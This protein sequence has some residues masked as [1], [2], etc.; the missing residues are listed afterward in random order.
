MTRFRAEWVDARGERVEAD[1]E[2]RDRRAVLDGLD[3]AA[4]AGLVRLAPADEPEGGADVAWAGRALAGLLR[5]G[6]PLGPALRHLAGAGDG[7]VA[8]ELERAAGAADEGASLAAVLERGPLGPALASPL[9][10]GMLEAGERASRLPDLLLE[11]SRLASRLTAARRRA[12]EALAYPTLVACL[13]VLLAATTVTLAGPALGDLAPVLPARPRGLA[14]RGARLARRAPGL[15]WAGA[16][17]ALAGARPRAARGRRRRLAPAPAAGCAGGAPPSA[18]RP[19]LGRAGARRAAALL[20]DAAPGLPPDAAG[21]LRRRA[22]GRRARRRRRRRPGG[23]RRPGGRRARGPA[24]PRVPPARAGRPPAHRGRGPR[25]RPG[26]LA[27]PRAGARGGRRRPPRGLALPREP[28]DVTPFWLELEPGAWLAAFVG[29]AVLLGSLVGVVRQRR[30]RAAEALRRRV[31]EQLLLAA[32][33]GL[34]LARALDVLGDEL[35]ARAERLPGWGDL[36]SMSWPFGAFER[37]GLRAQARAAH[38]LAADLAEGGLGCLSRA[39]GGAFP[40]PLPDLLA[41]AERQGTLLATLEEVVRLDDDALRLRGHV[42]GRLLYPAWVLGVM[43]LVLTFHELVIW[44]KFV[45]LSAAMGARLDPV[46]DTIAL[47]DRLVLARR[48][49]LVAAPLA[50]LGLW[51]AG[52]A[53]VTGRGALLRRVVPGLGGVARAVARARALRLLLAHLRAGAPLPDA[54]AALDRQGLLPAGGGA[55]AR[56]RA[57]EGH[58]IRA[59]LAASGVCGRDLLEPLPDGGPHAVEALAAVADRADRAARARIDLV[60]R[61]TLP[62]ALA[63]LGA[64]AAVSYLAPHLLIHAYTRS[65]AIW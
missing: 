1:L 12:L 15:A 6:V 64:L 36:T 5:Q 48:V 23:A 49:L 27:G 37:Q 51:L 47:A 11:A 30:R 26:R 56:A 34:P 14:R 46:A 16:L 10:R 65:V 54:V 39:P 18:G 35:A 63:L 52:S 24:R 29:L 13:G 50:L 44:D 17:G 53:L 20:D 9:V 8:R 55:A 43:L 3:P 28:L 2:G 4:R 33:R 40:A 59:A 62:F 45:E 41:G 7:V 32:R 57:V 31:L 38:D 22:A 58:G 61:A 42:R 21:R 25:P 60:A 19:R